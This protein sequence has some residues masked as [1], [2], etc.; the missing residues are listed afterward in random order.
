MVLPAT[1][2]LLTALITWS[3]RPLL[4]GLVMD[5]LALL[6]LRY[7]IKRFF[8]GVEIDVKQV[9][10]HMALYNPLS[11]GGAVGDE[12]F[13]ERRL[14]N[15]KEVALNYY[16]LTTQIF[17]KIWGP[18][19]S[20]AIEFPTEDRKRWQNYPQAQSVYQCYLGLALK[21]DENSVL[22]DFGCGTGGPTRCIAQF[23]GAKIKAV[24][25]NR[26]HLRQL[27]QFNREANIAHRI[28]PVCADYHDTKLPAASLD[29]VY[30]CESAACTYDHKVLC[31]EVYRVL[32]PGGRFTGFDWQMTDKFD[33][34]NL[35]HRQI[36]YLLELG[37]GVPRL[38][39]MDYMRQALREA[40]FQIVTVRNHSDFGVSLG[41]RPWD[42]LFN[43]WRTKFWVTSL[44][45]L[46]FQAAVRVGYLHPAYVDAVDMMVACREGMVRGGQQELDIFTP[47]AYWLAIKP[48]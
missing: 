25:I 20:M 14:K 43:Q 18:H 41:G 7:S 4:I 44:V 28:E 37:V 34:S 32:K 3:F 42:A 10:A 19:Y 47:M 35:E 1:I 8:D 45:R 40:G 11:A 9:E 22:G 17:H 33:E 21:A 38:V 13:K 16:N 6:L 15:Y 36:R 29:G 2:G 39:T 46:V 24:N 5:V 48:E 27:E 31:R 12:P 30:M 26:M 23:T